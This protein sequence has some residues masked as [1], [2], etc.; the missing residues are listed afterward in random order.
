[1]GA[2]ALTGR[3]PLYH[4]TV[5]TARGFDQD[6]VATLLRRVAD[7]L[8]QLGAVDVHDITFHVDWTEDGSWPSMT[9][10]YE[11][12][13]DEVDADD[14]GP[15]D[16]VDVR[17]DHVVALDTTALPPRVPPTTPVPSA[18]GMNVFALDRADAFIGRAAP[19]NANGH[20]DTNGNRIYTANVHADERDDEP[21]EAPD[22]P[23]ATL[24]P[25][26]ERIPVVGPG[27]EALPVGSGA[28]VVPRPPVVPRANPF[29][30]RN[31]EAFDQRALRR[32]KE[33]WRTTN[34]RRA[35]GRY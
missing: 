23:P 9:V 10:Y 34:R 12:D 5:A 33:L 32:L 11:V 15:D 24:V 17:D 2:V 8:D 30:L 25:V 22:E 31:A 35:N 16:V 3:L 21:D 6:D 29:P 19:P 14:L 18:W 26:A 7:A 13:D 27:E 28:P 4:F 20:G 1:M